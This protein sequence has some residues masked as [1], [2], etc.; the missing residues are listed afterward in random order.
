MPELTEVMAVVNSMGLH[1]RPAAKLVQTVLQFESDVQINVNGQRV[2]A[3]SIMGLLTLAAAQGTRMT[4]T[5][6]GPDADQAMQ[7][8]REL[9]A[10]GF[11]E[12]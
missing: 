10:S 4:V 1:A 7:A 5:A 3:K 9:I 11:G 8:V 2:N 12:S 6:Q